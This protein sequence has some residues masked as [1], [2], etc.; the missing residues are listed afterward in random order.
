MSEETVEMRVPFQVLTDFVAG[1]NLQDKQR[2]FAWLEQQIAQAEEALWDQDTALRAEI[3]EAR[4]AYLAGDFVT[5]DEYI[6]QQEE[7]Q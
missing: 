5:I 7:D 3:Q 4:A 2:L 1:L 6:Q